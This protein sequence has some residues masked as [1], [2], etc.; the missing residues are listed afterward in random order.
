MGRNKYLIIACAALIIAVASFK[1]IN[2]RAS[3][4]DKQVQDIAPVSVSKKVTDI[5][6]NILLDDHERP[7]TIKNNTDQ[8][9]KKPVVIRP[10]ITAESYLVANLKTGEKYIQL[11][12]DKAFPIASVSKLYTALVVHHILDKD[13]EISIT[14]PM[15]D[16][17]GDA[18]H[19][20]LGDKFTPE[21]LLY[22]L[23]MVSSND[24]AE[25]FAQSFG[26][27][28]F[29]ENMN[30]FAQEIGMKNTLFKDASG[31]SPQNVSTVN[32]LFEVAKYLYS[33]EP[34]ILSITRTPVYELAT[35]TTHGYHKLENIDPFTSYP[36]FVG[37]KTGRTNEAKEAMLTIFD[38][39]VGD[40]VY[41]IAIIILRSD[42][43]ERE[44]NI[45]KL[46]GQFMDKVSKTN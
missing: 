2:F 32:D 28:K 21:E 9:A 11:D 40:K 34:S 5:Y 35:T 3:E 23:L 12:P 8:S 45:E 41:P 43:G 33:S 36:E 17:Y 27:D 20:K 14:Q 25:A 16:A 6:S 13:T 37:G 31:L 18:G 29:M 22:P 10:Y 38:K 15:L 26:Y 4:L 39:K 46:L 30:A 44:I 19:L 7:I 42:F 1:D 24:A